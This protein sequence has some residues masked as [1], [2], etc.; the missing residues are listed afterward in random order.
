MIG[1]ESVITAIIA[2]FSGVMTYIM[3]DWKKCIMKYAHICIVC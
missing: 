3:N 2:A 1:F